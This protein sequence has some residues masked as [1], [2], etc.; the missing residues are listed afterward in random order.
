MDCAHKLMDL[1][2]DL[3]QVRQILEGT[4]TRNK[5]NADK[6]DVVVKFLNDLDEFEQKWQGTM[7]IIRGGEQNQSQG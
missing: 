5:D 6:L 7:R 2:D 1:K 3:Q 4:H